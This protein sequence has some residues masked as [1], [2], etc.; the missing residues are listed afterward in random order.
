[1][2]MTFTLFRWNLMLI[3]LLFVLLLKKPGRFRYD[4]HILVISSFPSAVGTDSQDFS[5]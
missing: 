5:T 2:I 3:C 1:M 4:S